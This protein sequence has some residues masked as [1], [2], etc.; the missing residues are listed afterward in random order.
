MREYW[1]NPAATA[2]ALRD[3]WDHTGDLGYLNDRKTT[4]SW[5]STVP[6]T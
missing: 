3:G 1:D 6:R 2:D 5:S 4:L